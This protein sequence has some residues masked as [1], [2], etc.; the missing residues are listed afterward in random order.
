MSCLPPPGSCS[1]SSAVIRS[2]PSTAKRAGPRRAPAQPCHGRGALTAHRP[3][4]GTVSGAAL[5]QRLPPSSRNRPTARP[6][7]SEEHSP[8]SPFPP[9]RTRPELCF[10]S[11]KCK[12]RGGSGNQ[13]QP[14]HTGDNWAAGPVESRPSSG[15]R[16]GACGASELCRSHSVTP[17]TTPPAR[18]PCRGL[19]QAVGGRR[20]SRAAGDRP[21]RGHVLQL[22]SAGV[23]IKRQR[24]R[25]RVR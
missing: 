7:L 4:P 22:V 20:A 2:R 8:F 1:R 15:R 12:G 9:G 11:G 5:H 16:H 10:R 3:G 6:H 14:C 24:D 21:V 17:P 18:H 13:A 25:H 23:V 19:R